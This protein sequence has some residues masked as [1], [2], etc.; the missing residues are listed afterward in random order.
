MK[1]HEVSVSADTWALAKAGTLAQLRARFAAG[2]A[3]FVRRTGGIA[4]VLYIA[5][6]D[7]CVQVP[8]E[9]ERVEVGSVLSRRAA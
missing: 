5:R 2:D 9:R 7:G 4:E 3:V 8:S 1:I 6:G